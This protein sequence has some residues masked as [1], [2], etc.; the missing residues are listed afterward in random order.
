MRGVKFTLI[1]L[2]VV[3]TALV[4]YG[5]GC[6]GSD[7]GTSGGGDTTATQSDAAADGTA[8][9]GGGNDT[10]AD[11]S[12]PEGSDDGAG[13]GN[14][15]SDGGSGSGPLTKAQFIKQADAICQKVPLKYEEARQKLE[16][17]AESDK[18]PKPSTA[19]INLAAAVPPLPEAAKEIEDLTP[20]TGDE[21]EAEAIVGALEAAAKG[22]E[23]KPN[24]ELTGPKSPFAEFQ[25][26]TKA[27][28]LQ[29][30]SRL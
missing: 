11:A 6:G 3:L 7:D 26:L 28:G 25:K 15:V 30:C 19:E 8:A 17:E 13:G 14:G 9:V 21:A 18:K 22:L 27:Y 10:E 24:S 1:G 5:Y 2:V 4:G 20:P 12:S 16:S 23:E 29:L